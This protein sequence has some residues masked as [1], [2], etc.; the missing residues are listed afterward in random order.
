ML[1]NLFWSLYGIHNHWKSVHYTLYSWDRRGG[2]N[3][4]QFE[5]SWQTVQIWAV[6]TAKVGDSLYCTVYIY[7]WEFILCSVQVGRG[8][9]TE[10]CIQARRFTYSK[11]KLCEIS[12]ENCEFCTMYINY[13]K[14]IRKVYRV[15]KSNAAHYYY[16]TAPTSLLMIRQGTLRKS[17]YLQLTVKLLRWTPR[18]GMK[19]CKTRIKFKYYIPGCY[20]VEIL[21]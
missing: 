11:L 12:A 18:A 5:E 8:L 15:H 17:G 3:T 13:M 7:M 2:V 21:A 14:I 16:V 19:N 20:R 6:Y 10:Q 1:C 4:V 9:K